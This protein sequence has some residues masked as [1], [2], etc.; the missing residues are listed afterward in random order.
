MNKIDG[1]HQLFLGNRNKTAGEGKTAE[2]LESG[3]EELSDLT[4][5]SS[6][7]FP[8]I[9]KAW[10]EKNKRKPSSPYHNYFCHKC[11]HAFPCSDALLSHLQNHPNEC[12]VTCQ[13]CDVNFVKREKFEDHVTQHSVENIVNNYSKKVG[14]D[15]NDIQDMVSQPEF[16]LV[17]GLKTTNSKFTLKNCDVMAEVKKALKDNSS[18]PA[19]TKVGGVINHEMKPVVIQPISESPLLQSPVHNMNQ[20]YTAVNTASNKKH[21][22]SSSMKNALT[23]NPHPAFPP[24]LRLFPTPDVT[25]AHQNNPNITTTGSDVMIKG[26]NDDPVEIGSS[27]EDEKETGINAQRPWQCVICEFAFPSKPQ[28]V[29]HCRYVFVALYFRLSL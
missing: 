5:F 19:G 18:G 25:G 28:C 27:S 26:T 6:I 29:K 14:T 2:D 20:L 15:D 16:M 12:N 17:L 24:Q 22:P 11:E 1:E 9:A 13:L 8:H 7:Q 21:R 10:C 23:N 3:F 4:D